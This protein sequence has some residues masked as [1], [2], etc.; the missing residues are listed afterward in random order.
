M[1]TTDWFMLITELMRTG[2]PMRKI[3]ENM[4]MVQLTEAMLRHYRAGTEPAHWRGE[5]LV[6]FWCKTTGKERELRPMRDRI[7]RY[8]ANIVGVRPSH[9]S[10]HLGATFDTPVSAHQGAK[11]DKAAQ[12]SAAAPG[13]RKPGPKPGARRKAAEAV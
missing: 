7:G 10:K 9:P 8:R 2:I 13:R 3:G 1:Q 12:E 5:L 4:G 11:A 6:T